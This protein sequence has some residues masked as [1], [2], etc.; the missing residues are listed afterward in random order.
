MHHNAVVSQSP[1]PDTS[2]YIRGCQDPGHHP[3]SSLLSLTMKVLCLPVLV[4]VC[5]LL[6]VSVDA[7]PQPELAAAG[8]RWSLTLHIAWTF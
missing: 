7:A 1:V 3:A 4:L 2:L 8:D 5:A 6:S